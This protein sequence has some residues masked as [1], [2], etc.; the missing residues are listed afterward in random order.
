MAMLVIPMARHV[1]ITRQAISPRLAMRTRWI[2]W[3]PSPPER[4]AIH[5]GGLTEADEM[6]MMVGVGVAVL[7]LGT[8]DIRGPSDTSLLGQKYG[9]QIFLISNGLNDLYSPEQHGI[10]RAA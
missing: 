6:V 2:C 9:N 1:L 10:S 4:G 5:K 7:M 3:V 8:A